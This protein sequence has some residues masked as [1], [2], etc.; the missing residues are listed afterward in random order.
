MMS[1]WFLTFC[2]RTFFFTTELELNFVL[3]LLYLHSGPLGSSGSSSVK[4][5]QV[6]S[7]ALS[8]TTCEQAR[9]KKSVFTIRMSFMFWKNPTFLSLFLVVC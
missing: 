5:A 3:K 9:L 7:V 1:Y 4:L 8:A 6:V 2:I